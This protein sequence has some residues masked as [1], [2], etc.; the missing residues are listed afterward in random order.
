MGGRPRRPVG[1]A[2]S[3]SRA[4]PRSRAMTSSAARDPDGGDRQ[5]V[6]V[7][8]RA[9]DLDG[10]A[11][12]RSRSA[13]PSSHQVRSAPR[14]AWRI[15]SP[16]TVSTTTRSKSPVTSPCR[17]DYSSRGRRSPRRS[18]RPQPPRP[19]TRR[20]LPPPMPPAPSQ[21]PSAMSAQGPGVLDRPLNAPVEASAVYPSRRVYRGCTIRDFAATE[22]PASLTAWTQ[23]QY[24]V[25]GGDRSR[26]RQCPVRRMWTSSTSTV[27]VGDDV[28]ADDRPVVRRCPS[29][30]D[31]RPGPG[32][33]RAR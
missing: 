27:G 19:P 18:G 10:T 24:G 15:S 4:P 29:D 2:S 11:R 26:Q 1:P 5:R 25:L 6:L 3:S 7:T 20:S 8:R 9:G 31:R 23:N 13:T 22:A 30:L 12:S 33:R 14:T 28:A 21:C 32:Q 17:L 16:S